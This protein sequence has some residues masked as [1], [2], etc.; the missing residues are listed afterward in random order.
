MW[1]Q[2]SAGVCHGPC[3]NKQRKAHASPHHSL[4][5]T[6]QASLPRPATAQSSPP[7]NPARQ[8]GCF[9]PPWYRIPSPSFFFSTVWAGLSG[10]LLAQPT[11]K[12]NPKNTQGAAT[13]P[14]RIDTTDRATRGPRST[15]LA[16][17]LPPL[18]YTPSGA[19]IKKQKING[20][21]GGGVN[22]CDFLLG[23]KVIPKPSHRTGLFV[24]GIA[25]MLLL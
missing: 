13:P 20:G 17:P 10:W 22:G 8:G 7:K 3:K 12:P 23:G 2:S 4:A 6:F 9:S 5:A 11:S 24:G 19:A 16:N 21:G 25:A 18:S 15:P 14:Q 1:L